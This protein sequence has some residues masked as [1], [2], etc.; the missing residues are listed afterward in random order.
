MVEIREIYPLSC[1]IRPSV[2]G[3][4]AIG[5]GSPHESTAQVRGIHTSLVYRPLGTSHRA[6]RVALRFTFTYAI[7]RRARILHAMSAAPEDHRKPLREGESVDVYRIERTLGAGGFGL[8]YVARD[9][10]LDRPIAL[11]EY[12]PLGL[13]QRLDNG[14]VGALGPVHEDAF[15]EGLK[16]F[17]TEARLMGRVDHLNVARVL[18]AF[19]LNGS[20]YIA[21]AYESGTPLDTCIRRRRKMSESKL[22]TLALGLLDALDAIHATGI[23]HRDI[24][25]SNILIARD[26]RPVLLD[27]GSATRVCGDRCDA[28]ISTVSSGY[29]PIELYQPERYAQ[30][31]WTDIYGTAAILYRIITGVRPAPPSGCQDLAE[32]DP[33]DSGAF[34]NFTLSAVSAGGG[35]FSEEFLAAIDHGL[36]TYPD[37]RPRSTR[38]WREEFAA[39][40]GDASDSAHSPAKLRHRR[41]AGQSDLDAC[42]QESNQ[43]LLSRARRMVATR[44]SSDKKR[45]RVLECCRRVLATDPTHDEARKIMKRLVFEALAE[46]R[47]AL[48]RDAADR[49]EA[50][51]RFAESVF[52]GDVNVEHLRGLLRKRRVEDE[53]IET[54]SN[55]SQGFSAA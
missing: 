37:L 8:T 13:S 11:K 54:S 10:Y 47:T 43:M 6:A 44:P 26:G 38:H 22:R 42:R 49:A 51:L 41:Q 21:M 14:V 32:T 30:G 46:A 24:K 45:S 18:S 5:Y 53:G 31:P 36:E 19:E 52:P 16:Q 20:G 12:M 4:V 1:P 7:S 33:T 25:P 50:L 39:S 9:V 29:S 23:I 28:A 34:Q 40:A 35:V 27:F 15:N 17:L 2:S 3:V 55:P 48:K